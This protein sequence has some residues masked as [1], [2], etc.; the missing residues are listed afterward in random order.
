[1]CPG[2]GTGATTD[3]LVLGLLGLVLTRWFAAGGAGRQWLAAILGLGAAVLILGAEQAGRFEMLPYAG[4]HSDLACSA[5]LAVGAQAAVL[6]LARSLP[7]AVMAPLAAM[8]AMSLSLYA[9]QVGWLAFDVRVWHPGARDDSWL[10]LV[11]LLAG[12]LALAAGW[13]RAVPRWRG[14]LEGPID[15]VTRGLAR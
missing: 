6:A 2:P 9:A 15:W 11:V 3:Q 8:G 14:P 12:A 4:R 10:N 1:M 5:A 7:G 13:R